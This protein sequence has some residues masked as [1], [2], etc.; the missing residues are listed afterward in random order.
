MEKANLKPRPSLTKEKLKNIL[1]SHFTAKGYKVDISALLASD[2][3]VKKNDWV[4][5]SIRLKQKQNSTLI[6]ISGYAP[7]ILVRLL[8]YGIIPILIL[9]PMWK[10]LEKEVKEYIV[11]KQFELDCD[12]A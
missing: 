8:M 5:V 12:A 1:S 3:Y 2:M 7:S 10:K 6:K 9:L 11:S 4:G